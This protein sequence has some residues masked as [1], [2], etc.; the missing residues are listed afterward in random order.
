MAA[1]VTNGRTAAA[2]TAAASISAAATPPAPPLAPASRRPPRPWPQALPPAPPL[3]QTPGRPPPLWL[4]P[5]SRLPP[6]PPHRHWHPL[7]DGRHGHGYR[8]T[9]R[10]LHWHRR[11]WLPPRRPPPALAPMSRRPPPPRLRPRPSPPPS[12]ARFG[13]VPTGAAMMVASW[14]RGLW[15]EAAEP[16]QTRSMTRKRGRLSED[17]PLRC[18]ASPLPAAATSAKK[19]RRQAPHRYRLRRRRRRERCSDHQQLRQAPLRERRRP[20][21]W[22]ALPCHKRQCRH[23]KGVGT[24]SC[25]LRDRGL[26]A[27]SRHCR[28]GPDWS[29]DVSSRWPSSTRSKQSG[30]PRPAVDKQLCL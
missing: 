11:P 23:S 13:V 15:T 3:A 20:V 6:P 5:P 14:W 28:S 21:C 26:D 17:L 10:H 8:R 18:P 22:V 16:K 9:V 1:V 24:G 29:A 27:S 19:R 25:R 30:R 2:A 7:H 12:A 4:P